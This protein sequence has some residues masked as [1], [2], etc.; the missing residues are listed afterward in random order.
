MALGL[1][2]VPYFD[3]IL[4]SYMP[5]K[6][7]KVGGCTDRASSSLHTRSRSSFFANSAEMVVRAKMLT[8]SGL[9]SIYTGVV[10]RVLRV[11]S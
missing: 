3:D 4:R 11:K 7:E 5:P 2:I 6:L 8:F 9:Q 10:P 1:S